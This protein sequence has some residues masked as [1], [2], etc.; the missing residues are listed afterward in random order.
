MLDWFKRAKKKQDP[1]SDWRTAWNAAI[2]SHDS[3]AP[4]LRQQL[5]ALTS[6]VPDVEV[7]LEMLDALDA[8]QALRRDL[9]DGRLPVV[10]THHRVVGADVCHF[11]APATLPDDGTPASGRVLFTASRAVFV[12]G[13]KT[14][15][16]PWHAVHTILRADRDLILVR[17]DQSAA[18]HYRFNTFT[19]AV[20]GA[21][22][23]R[24]LKSAR[25]SRL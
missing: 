8:L 9:A 18:A 20:S 22:L 2:D 5:E 12:G 16:A 6:S 10:E 3:A 11:A 15:T 19:D 4:A 25:A 7:E 14:A 17:A 24:H 23:A 13:G 1:L 21:A